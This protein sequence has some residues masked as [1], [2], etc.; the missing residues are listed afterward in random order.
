VAQVQERLGRRILL[1]NPSS[2]VAFQ[3]STMPEWE[4]LAE[5]S[6]RADCGILL[7]VNNVY[8]S[9][10]NL[11]FDPLRY[12]D[13]IPPDRVGQVHLAGHSDK[14]RWLLDSHD[15]PVPPPVWDLY[16][17]ALRR[18]GRVPALVEWDGAIPPLEEVVAQSRRAAAVEAEELGLP[19]GARPADRGAGEAR[20]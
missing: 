13:G 6:R 8:V 11:G 20:P 17:Q 7:D 1:E 2:Y 12:L 18:L 4:F 19:P 14:G 10:R 16:R 15:A 9:S 5:L 3:G